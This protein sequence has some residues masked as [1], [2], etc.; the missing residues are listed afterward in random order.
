M[1]WAPDTAYT[2][3]ADLLL[4][5]DTL[6]QHV[7]LENFPSEVK[8]EEKW[9]EDYR[10]R[11]VAYYDEKMH[12]N[13]SLSVSAK[14][15]SV[16]NEGSR[17]LSLGCNGTT[18]DMIVNNDAQYTL[19]RCREYSLLS[20]LVVSCETSESKELV[21]K[22]WT[23]YEQMFKKIGLIATNMVNLNYWGG[24]ITGP[25]RTA[26]YLQLSQSRRDMYQTI[27]NIMNG[28]GWDDSGVYP[29]NAERF[30]FD[31][32]STSINRIVKEADE[33]YSEYEGKER[34]KIFD[35]TIKETKNAIQELRPIVK[36]WIRLV[37]ILDDEITH[38]FS[39][40]HVER[41]ASYMIMQ[42]ASIV[43]D[44]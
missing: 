30:L 12:R 20:Q 36:E 44:K 18:M 9:M 6:Y 7:R 8:L 14:A 23:L 15:D 28:E 38:D 13:D 29:D 42:W 16:L 35:E 41:A 21:Y 25:L 1:F 17:L 19:D 32:C 27:L 26:A 37:D 22:E 5:L 24:S 4:L 40:H 3:N 34:S 39:R 31:C 2:T 33:F 43:T 11:L 10:Y